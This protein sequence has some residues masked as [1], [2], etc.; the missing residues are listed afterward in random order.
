M[1]L[2]TGHIQAD[3]V[4]YELVPSERRSIQR[5]A[6]DAPRSAVDTSG[7]VFWRN[8]GGQNALRVVVVDIHG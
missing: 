7:S 5:S 8:T 6:R 4:Q 1:T 2:D 3:H